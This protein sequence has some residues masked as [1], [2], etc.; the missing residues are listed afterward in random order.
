MINQIFTFHYVS[1]KTTSLSPLV[2]NADEFTFHYV[3]IKTNIDVLLIDDIQYLHSTM[4]LLKPNERELPGYKRTIFTF[5][6]VS[7]KTLILIQ[8]F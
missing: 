3:S 1:I 5:H 8:I 2:R 6:Y 4:Y 7:I